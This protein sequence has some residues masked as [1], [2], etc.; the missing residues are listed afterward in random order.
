MRLRIADRILVGLAGLII[1]AG[2]AAAVA[3]A[4][5]QVDVIGFVTRVLTSESTVARAAVIIGS[6]L[7]VLLGGYCFFVLFRHRTRR[8]RFVM[9]KNDSGELNISIKA[10]ENMVSKCLEQHPEINIQQMF[11]QNQKDGLLIRLRGSVAGGVSIPLTVEA[12]Q[13]QI[14]QYVTACS[15]VEIKN[16]TV[17]IDSSGPEADSAPFRIAPPTRP[18]LNEDNKAAAATAAVHV[19]APADAPAAAPAEAAAPAQEAAPEKAPAPAPAPA[20]MPVPEE[21]ED[22]RPLHQRLF[23]PANEPCIVPVPPVDSGDYAADAAEEAGAASESAEAVKEAAAESAAAFEEAGEEMKAA[24]SEA[25]ENAAEEAK[26]I[27]SESAEAVK[28]EA[29]EAVSEAAEAVAEEAKD[30]SSEADEE[31]RKAE[32]EKEASLKEF[33]EAL[34]I[35]DGRMTGKTKGEE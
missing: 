20:P 17:M 8:D 10:L 31:K 26:E 12:A 23:S 3:Q 24:V 27:V 2:A 35:F 4:F 15:G 11:L 13:R 22:D 19:A 25:A 16:I 32:A 7:L 29:K 33:K 21:D 9:Q 5:F 6:L 30:L 28:E 14:K 1:L 18:L 34:N